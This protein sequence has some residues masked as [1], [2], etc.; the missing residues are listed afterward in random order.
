[1]ESKIAAGKLGLAKMFLWLYKILE[2]NNKSNVYILSIPSY[3][4][5]QCTA[6]IIILMYPRTETVRN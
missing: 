4:A 6:K 5:L 1:M 2:Q 3:F